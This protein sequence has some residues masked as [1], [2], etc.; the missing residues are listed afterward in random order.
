M[1]PARITRGKHTGRHAGGAAEHGTLHLRAG[2]LGTGRIIA[3]TDYWPWSGKSV[4]A[5]YNHLY[6]VARREGYEIDSS[7]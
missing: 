3:S 1:K 4:E 5:A 6:A 2:R 7:Q